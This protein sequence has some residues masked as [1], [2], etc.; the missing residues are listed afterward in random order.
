MTI[1]LSDEQ[2]SLVHPLV[3]MPGDP[4]RAQY[5]AK[6]FLKNCQLL[7]NVRNIPMYSGSYRGVPVTVVAS[8]M[9]FG[10]IGIYAYELYTFFHVRCIIRVGTAASYQANIDLKAIVHAVS[11]YSESNYPQVLLSSK[12]KITQLPATT[13]T[14]NVIQTTAQK[15]KINLHE[16]KIHSS[17]IFYHPDPHFWKL[18]R[19]R[20]CLAVDM[21]ATAL[22]TH[23]SL[24][25]KQAGC[26]L[27]ITDSFY[28]S[29]KFTTQERIS[30]VDQMI[31]LGLESLWTLA[32]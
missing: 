7:S 13:Q 16:G 21:E 1:H 31:T 27:T 22:F 2:A 23:A 24:L 11:V 3:L 6:K 20:N 12:N 26:L 17:N 18:F 15:L 5:I 28:H 9:G 19:D 14:V 30:G 10:S 25:N 32:Q 29:K 8:G 4:L